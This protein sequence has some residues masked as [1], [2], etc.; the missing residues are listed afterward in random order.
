[1]DKVSA[2]HTV[3]FIKVEC[4]ICRFL[5]YA[6]VTN[7]FTCSTVFAED[8]TAIATDP[9]T[10]LQSMA[11]PVSVA[12]L[13]QYAAQ[14]DEAIINL[15]LNTGL[16][17]RAVEPNRRVT[18]LHNAAA[19]GHSRLCKLL[20]EQGADVNAKDINGF[21]PLINAVYA[22]QNE[23]MRLL[24]ENK[25]D[26]NA[27]PKSG[28]TALNI[29]VQRND[30]VSAELLLKAKA[31]IDLVDTYGMSPVAYAKKLQRTAMAQRF[32]VTE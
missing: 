18:A 20:I 31:S 17:V 28:S 11:V 29:A 16:S 13:V 6:T 32:A 26:S 4:W 27:V 24:L 5:I 7:I 23:T 9:K 19:N 12:S 15:L 8:Y 30:M 10:K 22:G 21:T 14:G 1:L 25:A 3:N 2:T